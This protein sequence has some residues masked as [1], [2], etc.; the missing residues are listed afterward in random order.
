MTSHIFLL[1]CLSLVLYSSRILTYALNDQRCICCLEVRW[2]VWFLS[3][4]H[5][6]VMYISGVIFAGP[7]RRSRWAAVRDALIM[8]ESSRQRAARL[9]SA[10]EMMRRGP[11]TRLNSQTCSLMG[12]NEMSA[13]RQISLLSGKNRPQS[14]K[15]HL[16]DLLKNTPRCVPIFHAIT[17]S[18]VWRS[19]VKPMHRDW[20]TSVSGSPLRASHWWT[21][22][23][24]D[25]LK[26]SVLELPQITF[27]VF[28]S[29]LWLL[30][31]RK[32]QSKNLWHK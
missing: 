27:V 5:Y 13:S 12:F 6:R 22:T 15:P 3:C 32:K 20:N 7:R 2:R 29:P 11:A 4:G 25:F 21:L 16:C 8:S 1:S 18:E 30:S 24:S 10:C 17:A 23:K 28:I 9:S 26:G 31:S 14:T 19:W